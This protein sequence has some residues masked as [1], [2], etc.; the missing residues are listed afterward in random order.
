VGASW[1]QYSTVLDVANPGHSDLRLQVYLNT[2]G[3]TLAADAASL[4][5]VSIDPPLGPPSLVR[6]VG[7]YGPSSLQSISTAVNQGWSEIGE[8]GGLGTTSSPYTSG[9]LSS[10]DLAA[11]KAIS[12][13]NHPVT[14]L[15][16]WT[17]SA[18]VA[19]DTWHSDGYSAGQYVAAYLDSVSS[20]VKP[21]FVILDP[22][23]YPNGEP[24][25][26]P[27]DSSDWASWIQG[28]SAGILSVDGSL[29]PALYVDQYEYS[30]FSISSLRLPVFVAIA[31]I[32]DNYPA[33]GT[34]SPLVPTLTVTAR[35]RRGA[36]PSRTKLRCRAGVPVTTPCNLMTAVRTVARDVGLRVLEARAP[37]RTTRSAASQ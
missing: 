32:L 3:Q 19:T 14:W 12:A 9:L 21:A 29:T 24:N 20:R 22:E 18:P 25:E 10:P 2:A 36:R 7:V 1:Q 4:P 31:P 35:L 17:V 30:A 34:A 6:G 13:A 11:S 37:E 15:S 8:T 28:W 16:F 26:Y 33:M 27:G 5:D 23:G